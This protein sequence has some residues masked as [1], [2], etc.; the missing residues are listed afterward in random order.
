MGTGI[1]MRGKDL[2]KFMQVARD[3]NVIILVRHTNP[4][5]LKYIGKA[6]YYPKPA[7]CKAKTADKNPPPLTTFVQGRKQTFQPEIAGLVVHPG[8]HPNAF[9]PRKVAKA[10]SEWLHTLELIGPTLKA[11]KVDPADP[12]S[13]AI[14]GV[15]RK[16]VASARWSWRVDIDPKSPHFGCLQLK[17]ERI[18]WSYIH[19]DYDLKDVI[20]R[21]RLRDNRTVKERLDG[22]PNNTPFLYER[23]FSTI[24]ARL[25]EL[26]GADMVQHGA[27]AQFGWHGADD[28]IT[29]AFPDWTHK[30][31]YDAVTVQLWYEKIRRKVLAEKGKDYKTDP[32]FITHVGMGDKWW[33]T[34]PDA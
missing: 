28:P 15:E 12:A 8:F 33:E 23:S 1:G 26:I 9:E 4:D 19:G 22:V 6:G 25:N 11:A 24:Q 21:N 27:E 13:W 5:S 2:Q 17:N 18:G 7:L 32:R 3:F 34:Q 30:L 31:F 29:A 16:A 14:W 20:V 10:A